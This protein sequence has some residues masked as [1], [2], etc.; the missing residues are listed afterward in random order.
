MTGANEK[1]P[2]PTENGF[3]KPFVGTQHA[4]SAPKYHV[5]WVN[6]YVRAVH[7]Q[8][9]DN[10]FVDPARLPRIKI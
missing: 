1:Y 8:N 6:G 3:A 4:V 9:V 10:L 7:F 5:F 2:A